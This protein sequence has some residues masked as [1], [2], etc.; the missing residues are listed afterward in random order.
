[1]RR[2]ND[3]DIAS[4]DKQAI[5]ASLLRHLDIASG[6]RRARAADA[7]PDDHRRLKAW[8]SERL[9]HTY[10][11]LLEEPRYRPAAAFFLED[12]YGVKD[13]SAR[14]AEVE[15][16]LPTLIQML[17]RRALLT[18]DEAMRMDALSESLDADMVAQLR[19]LGRADTID[20]A[21]YRDAYRA[22]GRR[23]DRE[24]QIALVA[25]IGRSLERLTHVPMLG[26]TLRLMKGPA[27]KAG[28]GNLQD[29]LESGFHAFREM[30]DAS[31]FVATIDRRETEFMLRLLDGG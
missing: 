13:F 17:P 10:R 23:S 30:G 24:A 11:D 22:C 8:Q 7:H 12:L 20:E 16:I 9:A 6:L 27:K 14:D 4:R 21:T 1:M 25:S 18:L 26:A 28:L 19:R 29:F 5:G 31:R 2:M 3:P 15:R